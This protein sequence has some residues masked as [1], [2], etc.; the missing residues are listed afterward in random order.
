MRSADPGVSAAGASSTADATFA[1]AFVKNGRLTECAR[2]EDADA[3]ENEGEAGERTWR[4]RALNVWSH[5]YA[6]VPFFFP[7]KGV[8][9]FRFSFFV[10]RFR[11]PVTFHNSNPRPRSRRATEGGAAYAHDPRGH[12]SLPPA[13]DAAAAAE[14]R[15]VR[16]RLVR[17]KGDSEG[18]AN[19]RDIALFFFRDSRFFFF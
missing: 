10:F 8:F 15:G 4:A 5:G 16:T 12:A 7:A 3:D 18:T 13:S 17:S 1:F 14:T 6:T 19:A 2:R 9:R 11:Y